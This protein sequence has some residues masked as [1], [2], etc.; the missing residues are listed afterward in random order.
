MYAV[1]SRWTYASIAIRRVLA[2][3]ALHARA[4]FTLVEV[5]GDK[6]QTHDYDELLV[7]LG[8]ITNNINVRC[9]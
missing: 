5:C 2:R 3:P 8:K 7:K 4:T 9:N 1:V 6:I